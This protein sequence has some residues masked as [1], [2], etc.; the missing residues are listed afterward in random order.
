MCIML[1]TDL[2]NYE[3]LYIFFPLPKFEESEKNL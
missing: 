2:F 3:F 1:F